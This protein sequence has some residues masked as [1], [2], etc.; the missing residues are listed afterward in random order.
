MAVQQE[1]LLATDHNLSPMIYLSTH[2]IEHFMVTPY[3][4]IANGEEERFSRTLGK[5][6]KCAHV[7]GK[8][9]RDELDK[10]LLNIVVP[11][12]QSLNVRHLALFF[13]TNSKLTSQHSKRSNR[14]TVTKHL[15]D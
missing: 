5:T 11:H 9:W 10:L 3:W 7:Q 2:N 4:P 8:N 14:K 6:I 1:S 12:I 13:H 15:L